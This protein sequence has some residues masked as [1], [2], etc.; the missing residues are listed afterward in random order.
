L[1]SGEHILS[2]GQLPWVAAMLAVIVLVGAAPALRERQLF[3]VIRPGLEPP[4]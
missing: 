2:R 4:N 1:S 3:G